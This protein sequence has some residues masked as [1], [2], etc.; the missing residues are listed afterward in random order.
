MLPIILPGQTEVN[1]RGVCYTI[2]AV[3]LCALQTTIFNF[4]SIYGIRPNLLLAFVVCV[5]LLRGNVEG[6]MTGLL[7]GILTDVMGYGSFGIHALLYMYIGIAIGFFSGKFYRVRLV[8]AF[9]FTFVIN[10]TYGLLYYFFAFYIWGKGGM[11]F[12]I[13]NKIFPESLYTAFLSILLLLM[14][15]HIN[16]RINAREA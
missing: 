5:A 9:S 11:W 1:V 14:I 13:S 6:G 16:N 3:L 8:V 4:I 12:A 7:C 15:S 2:I 10:L